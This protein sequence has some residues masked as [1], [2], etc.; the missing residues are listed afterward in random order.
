MIMT[1]PIVTLP[2]SQQNMLAGPT[3]EHH[4]VRAYSKQAFMWQDGLMNKMNP[5]P[6]GQAFDKP[7]V[8]E[9]DVI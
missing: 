9:R 5:T 6:Q 8:A 3:Q 2:L 1:H 4:D 7:I